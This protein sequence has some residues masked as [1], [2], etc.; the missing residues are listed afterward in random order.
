MKYS[1]VLVG[2][3]MFF[4]SIPAEIPALRFVSYS[5]VGAVINV[6]V[7]SVNGTAADFDGEF[8]KYS[9]DEFLVFE[10]N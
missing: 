5:G 9:R 4:F 7:S 8:L 10:M 1:L 6:R 3:D 2:S